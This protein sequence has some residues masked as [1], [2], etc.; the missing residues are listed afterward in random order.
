MIST[1]K[2]ILLFTSFFLLL[3]CNMQNKNDRETIKETVEAISPGVPFII[4]RESIFLNLPDDFAD[5]NIKGIVGLTVY[6][7][8]TENL[9]GFKIKKLNVEFNDKVDINFVNES[10]IKRPFSKEEYPKEVQKYYPIIEK[11]VNGLRF[12]RDERIP[13]R[14]LNEITFIARLK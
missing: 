13:L 1:I 6:I 8:S 12:E 10:G 4:D 5:E 2:Y 3:Q 9:Q 11:Y 7:D 14:E